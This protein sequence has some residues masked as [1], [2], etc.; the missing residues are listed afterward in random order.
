MLRGATQRISE[1]LRVTTWGEPGNAHRNVRF[2]FLAKLQERP[3]SKPFFF[4]D[5]TQ[6]STDGTAA[7]LCAVIR[8][9][10][11]AF[12]A[13]TLENLHCEKS[14]QFILLAFVCSVAIADNST[15]VTQQAKPPSNARDPAAPALFFS[16]TAGARCK[17]RLEHQTTQNTRA[18]NDWIIQFDLNKCP[19]A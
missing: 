6:K 9:T 13:Y 3:R 11:R 12:L 14:L 10:K 18:H 16:G 1:H 5:Y 7:A 17:G 2:H 19:V 8:C 4:L 15:F